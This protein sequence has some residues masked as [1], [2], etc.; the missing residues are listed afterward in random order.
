MLIDIVSKM[1][2]P[3]WARHVYLTI[4]MFAYFTIL[5]FRDFARIL[6][7]ESLQFRVV[8]SGRILEVGTLQKMGKNR[9]RSEHVQI[10]LLTYMT[11]FTYFQEVPFNT[12]FY[13]SPIVILS[14]NH[15]YNLKVKG[16]RPPENN[17]IS[18]WLEVSLLFYSNLRKQPPDISRD[19]SSSFLTKW[20]KPR[21]PR[22]TTQLLAFP[23]KDVCGTSVEI[24]YW[25]RVLPRS[26]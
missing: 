26:R 6:Y 21:K 24:P 17:I 12:T 22:F 1:A 20:R 16:S 23:W 4:L 25:W 10:H 19:A 15:K 9:G 3:R 5:K 13:K 2:I 14:V 18:A 8:D 7:F 11:F